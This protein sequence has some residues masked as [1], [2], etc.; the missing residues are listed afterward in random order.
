[1]TLISCRY[2][3][4]ILSKILFIE[5]KKCFGE[6]IGDLGPSRSPPTPAADAPAKF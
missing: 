4:S 3:E 2:V 6:K 1:M 5:F